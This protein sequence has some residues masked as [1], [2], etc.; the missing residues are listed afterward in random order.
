MMLLITHF[1]PAFPF[2][3]IYPT[4]IKDLCTMMFIVVVLRCLKFGNN[5]KKKPIGKQW[6]ILLYIYTINYLFCG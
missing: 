3:G 5:L 4:K 2:L 6:N 1:N